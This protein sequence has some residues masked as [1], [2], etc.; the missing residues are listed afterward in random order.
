[1]IVGDER[2]L[3]EEGPSPGSVRYLSSELRDEQEEDTGNI[4]ERT[5]EDLSEVGSSLLNGEAEMD[6]AQNAIK[7]YGPKKTFNRVGHHL[8]EEEID[9][10]SRNGMTESGIEQIAE[11]F[12][13]RVYQNDR[14]ALK[15]NAELFDLAGSFSDAIEA[16]RR[17]YHEDDRNVAK[18]ILDSFVR[19][20]EEDM[21]DIHEKYWEIRDSRRKHVRG[22]QKGELVDEFMKGYRQASGTADYQSIERQY[23]GSASD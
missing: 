1:M 17:N 11:H 22:L 6:K 2:E 20:E 19:G 18:Y 12:A 3:P 8:R 5:E 4:L 13:E 9:W 7:V 15:E 23:P 16:A 14:D 10:E 21:E